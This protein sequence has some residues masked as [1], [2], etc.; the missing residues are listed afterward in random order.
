MS[1]LSKLLVIYSLF[2]SLDIPF[3]YFFLPAAAY[4]WGLLMAVVEKSSQNFL[5]HL[6]MLVQKLCIAYRWGL[7]VVGFKIPTGCFGV[8]AYGWPGGGAVCKGW[9]FIWAKGIQEPCLLIWE[10]TASKIRPFPSLWS[11]PL[12]SVAGFWAQLLRRHPRRV[13]AAGGGRGR[14]PAFSCSLALVS[15]PLECD[16]LNL[17]QI[18][19]PY[20]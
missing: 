2:F 12:P 7:L 17:V 8:P 16:L 11:P 14:L 3:Q 19:S 5:R 15:R 13:A 20:L 1:S 6:V 4:R 18:L 9:P 10:S